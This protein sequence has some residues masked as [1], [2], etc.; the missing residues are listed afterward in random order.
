MKLTSYLKDPRI[1][2][3]VI[4]IIALA[5]LDAAYGGPHM[6]H[7]GVEFLIGGTQIPVELEHGVDTATMSNLL[8]T[9]QGHLS[10]FGPQ[11]GDC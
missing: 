6:L 5:I 10:N 2:L 4:L 9:L 1:A 8:T 3:P 11:A 7:L